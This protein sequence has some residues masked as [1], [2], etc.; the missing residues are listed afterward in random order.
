MR[1]PIHFLAG[2]DSDRP[3][4]AENF[5]RLCSRRS[6]SL[7]YNT[8]T[9]HFNWLARERGGRTS[10]KRKVSLRVS[11]RDSLPSTSGRHLPIPPCGITHVLLLPQLL[12]SR[13]G[14][15]VVYHPSRLSSTAINTKCS[16]S[17]GEEIFCFFQ[18]ETTTATDQQHTND[19]LSRDKR[20]PLCHSSLFSFPFLLAY[21]KRQSPFF[22]VSRKKR[23]EGTIDDQR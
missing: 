17:G 4:I 6:F 3:T 23:E 16:A 15:V 18:P 7:R 14:V 21:H 8:N 2:E 9:Q 1:L 11:C 5:L 20:H 22:C 12:P 10:P 19:R 13:N